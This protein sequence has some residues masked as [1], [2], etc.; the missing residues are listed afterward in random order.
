MTPDDIT[1]FLDAS[2]ARHVGVVAT[3]RGDGAPHLVLVWYWYDG[4]A[5]H[6]WTGEDRAWVRQL[7]RDP[8]VAFSVQE[9]S[10]PFAAVIIRGTADVLP[11]DAA[12][13]RRIT[14]RYI[15]AADVDAYM[16]TWSV[17]QTIVKITP[18]DIRAWGRGY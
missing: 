13:V 2:P 14:E 6:I 11:A 7:R 3:V 12:I 5:V 15:P 16:E 17:L 8:R 1:A 4:A 10:A 9:Q 18:R